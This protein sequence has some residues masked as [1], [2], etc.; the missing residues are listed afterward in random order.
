MDGKKDFLKIP[1]LDLNTKP[2]TLTV[3]LRIDEFAQPNDEAPLFSGGVYELNK[4]MHIGVRLEK[5]FMGFYGDD[6]YGRT[7]LVRGQWYFLAFVQEAEY[8]EAQ[9]GPSGG[10]E[11]ESLIKA[12]WTAKQK[13]FVNGNLDSERD[14]KPYQDKLEYIGSFWGQSKLNGAIDDVR[15]YDRALTKEELQ[16]LYQNNTPLKLNPVLWLS[17]D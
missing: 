13:L 15:V 9:T 12:H 6:A 5:P 1:A 14:C 2:F 10:K 7:E 4:G 8:H 11:S 16:S 3:W 17:F